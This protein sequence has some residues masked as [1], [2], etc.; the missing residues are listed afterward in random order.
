[1]G[2]REELD[3]LPAPDVPAPVAKAVDDLLARAVR[4]RASDLVWSVRGR[5]SGADASGRYARESGGSSAGRCVADR[6]AHTRCSRGSISPS[7]TSQDGRIRLVQSGRTV[8]L[9]VSTLP[10]QHGESVVLRVLDA[11]ES[12]R[13]L[14]D[15]GSSG[16][17]ARWAGPHIRPPARAFGGSWS[18]GLR[19]DHDLVCSAGAIEHPGTKNPDGRGSGGERNQRSSQFP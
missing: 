18:D 16:G 13:T 3:R 19:Q 8:D 17:C 2:G 4:D 12:G 1:M 6:V 11:P 9:R 15:L 10:T 5:I 7:A 14:T